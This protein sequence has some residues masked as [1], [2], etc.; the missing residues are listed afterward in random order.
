MSLCTGFSL[1]KYVTL[2]QPQQYVPDVNI[3]GKSRNIFL[4]RDDEYE[5]LIV[6]YGRGQ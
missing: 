1:K 3:L 5:R 6:K 2:P 4:Y